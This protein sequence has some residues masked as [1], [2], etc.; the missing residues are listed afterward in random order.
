[1]KFV[2]LADRWA[3]QYTVLDD[4]TRFRVLRLYPRLTPQASLAFLGELRRAF[5]FRVRRSQC[6]NGREFPWRLP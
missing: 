6:D 3:F 5:P 2:K 4:C 1:V